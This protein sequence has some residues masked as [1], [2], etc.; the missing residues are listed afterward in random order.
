MELKLSPEQQQKLINL[1][2]SFYAH[3]NEVTVQMRKGNIK[4]KCNNL[5]TTLIVPNVFSGSKKRNID[6]LVDE[7]YDAEVDFDMTVKDEE[8][9]STLLQFTKDPNL[10]NGQKILAYSKVWEN[11]KKRK[12]NGE[13]SITIQT[14]V[15][16]ITNRNSDRLLRIANKSSQVMEVVG[17][18][19]PRDFKLITP[20]WLQHVK[21]ADFEEFLEKTKLKYRKGIE[22]LAGARE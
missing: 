7:A 18:Y 3:T 11:C 14:E 5:E 15:N 12:L 8:N 4:V 20:T 1:Y 19:F 9:L 21:S 16:T 22:H 6:L 2:K 10:S 13:S 17:D